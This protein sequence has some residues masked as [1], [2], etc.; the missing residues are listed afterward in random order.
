MC[1]LDPIGQASLIISSLSLGIQRSQ[2]PKVVTAEIQFINPPDHLKST[3]NNVRPQLWMAAAATGETPCFTRSKVK[4]LKLHHKS[5][6]L[7][8]EILKPFLSN[9][10]PLHPQS[11]M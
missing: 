6:A 9:T 7:P 4:F 11:S 8:D 10:T 2:A 3:F 5:K 1:Q